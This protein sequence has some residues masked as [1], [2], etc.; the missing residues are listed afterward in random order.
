[1]WILSIK[2]GEMEGVQVLCQCQESKLFH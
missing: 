1:M 2:V